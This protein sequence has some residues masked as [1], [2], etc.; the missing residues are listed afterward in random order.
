M[1]VGKCMLI[2]VVFQFAMLVQ[3]P[4]VIMIIFVIHLIRMLM[5]LSVKAIEG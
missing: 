3:E 2:I 4:F 5:K 1:Q